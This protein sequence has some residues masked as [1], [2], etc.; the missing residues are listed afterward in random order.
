MG[1]PINH[2]LFYIGQHDRTQS[3]SQ[4]TGISVSKPVRNKLVALE[5][6]TVRVN[7]R[8]IS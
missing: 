8:M 6:V 3:R 4:N 5:M 1:I 7:G 2:H